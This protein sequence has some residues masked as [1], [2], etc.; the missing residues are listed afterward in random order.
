MCWRR[1]F[2]MG[3]CTPRIIHVSIHSALV[4][5]GPRGCSVARIKKT[6]QGI[7]KTQQVIR[8]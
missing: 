2:T 3:S 7:L 1:Q 8:A 5:I 6:T 4:R